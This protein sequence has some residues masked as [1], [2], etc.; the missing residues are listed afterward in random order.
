MLSRSISLMLPLLWQNWSLRQ[1]CYDLALQP[2]LLCFRHTKRIAV[3]AS[4]NPLAPL[5]YRPHQTSPLL[6]CLILA[7]SPC[8]HLR[9][10]R[11]LP[12]LRAS[13]PAFVVV[14]PDYGSR[15][16]AS[17][18]HC[19]LDFGTVVPSLLVGSLCWLPCFPPLTA[20]L[21]YLHWLRHRQLCHLVLSL[22]T[23]V[24][25][26]CRQCWMVLFRARA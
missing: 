15:L 10:L 4:G 6:L 25:L 16:G 22:V 24:L 21:M 2:P 19:S 18:L 26:A 12:L 5:P 17:C 1:R 23:T 14:D 13:K 11:Q 9:P 7:A 8:P 3:L 20:L